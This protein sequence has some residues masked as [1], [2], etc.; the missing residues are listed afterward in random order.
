[1][2]ER[3]LLILAKAP[4]AGHAKSRMIPL[5]GED[6][7]AEL[8]QQLTHWLLQKL[9]RATNYEPEYDVELWCASDLHHPFFLACAHEFGITLK[10]QQGDDLGDRQFYAMQS[11]LCESDAVVMVGSDVASLKVGDI[12]DAFEQIESGAGI[13]IAPADDGG[14]GLLGGSMINQ[15]LFGGIT[16]GGAQVYS[17]M[18]ANLNSLEIDW[19]QLAAVWDIDRPED[20]ARLRGELMLSRELL[21]ILKVNGY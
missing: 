21:K 14:Y 15:E 11:A 5:L 20:L 9:C 8:H 2:S 1:M 18:V 13:V 7:A 19:Q 6:G 3:K 17:G 4:I 16:W 12:C 10:L